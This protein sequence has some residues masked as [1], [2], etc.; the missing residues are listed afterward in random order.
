MFSVPG[1]RKLALQSAVPIVNVVTRP[2]ASITE[3]NFLSDVAGIL[4][5]GHTDQ[6]AKGF[7]F[8]QLCLLLNILNIL[9]VHPVF[10]CG[11]LC[12]S[13]TLGTVVES[14]R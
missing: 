3:D 1:V 5:V 13:G 11:F 6:F 8:N 4:T 14:K 9:S 10:V 2:R 12:S 7:G